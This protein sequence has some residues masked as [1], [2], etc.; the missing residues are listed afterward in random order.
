MYNDCVRL[1][2]H[3]IKRRMFIMK[4][5]IALLL[6]LTML[7]AFAGCNTEKPVETQPQE[8]KPAET[9]PKETQA[10]ETTAPVETEPAVLA[11]TYAEFVAAEMDTEVVI[12]AYVA[13]V[14]SW[15]NGSMH[16]Y[17]LTEEGGYYIYSLACTEEEAAQ[18]VPG[19][20]VRFTGFK[21]AWAGEVE[22]MD[23][24]FEILESDA[25]YFGADDATDLL[26]TDELEAMMNDLVAFNGL[27]V[28]ASKDANGN[29]V[30]FLYKWDGSGSQG[31]DLYFNVSLNG[32]TYT[33]TVNAYMIGTGSDSEVYKTIEAL[34]IGDV[35]NV[36]GF[37]YWYNA[38]QP[39]I[40]SVTV[41]G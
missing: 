7:V 15:W 24:T 18:F 28:E 32:Q 14:E 25:A 20:L 36:E 13:A 19:T 38:P 16:I 41:A 26:G 27:T 1:T 39:H 6:A 21:G 29:D 8:T 10:P 33:F 34:N 22:I 4:K 17:A 30:A 5:L 37:L 40:T 12:E 31:D 9:Q 3:N 35:I 2:T 11:M 23:A